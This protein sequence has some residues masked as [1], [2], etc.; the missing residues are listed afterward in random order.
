M[1]SLRTKTLI[2]LL[3]LLLLVG[4]VTFFA[5]TRLMDQSLDAYEKNLAEERL[6][7]VSQGLELSLTTFR[8]SATDYGQWDATLHFMQGKDPEY[9]SREYFRSNLNNLHIDYVLFLDQNGQQHA[10]VDGTVEEVT[11]GETTRSDLAPLLADFEYPATREK[12][13]DNQGFLLRLLGGQPY[14]LAFSAITA[15][16]PKPEDPKVGWLVMARR[17]DD[18]GMAELRK[19]T[20]TH[21]EIFPSAG[22]YLQGRDLL[23]FSLQDALGPTPIAVGLDRP[24]SLAAQRELSHKMLAYTLAFMAVLAGLLSI[25]IIERLILCR[26]GLFS[27]LALDD[28]KQAIDE[29]HTVTWPVKGEDELDNL[30]VSL[31]QLVSS[32]GEA[33]KRMRDDQGTLLEA[34]QQ[35]EY[36]NRMKDSFLATIS[37]ELRTP[38]NGIIGAEELLKASQPSPYQKEC[39]DTLGDASHLMLSMVERILLFSELQA[40][41][42]QAK[43]QKVALQEWAQLMQRFWST[44]F[45]HCPAKFSMQVEDTSTPWV[46]VDTVKV[47]QLVQELLR[48]AAKFTTKGEVS[49]QLRQ[50]TE[51]E[52]YW[53]VVDVRD[54]GIGIPED[55]LQKVMDAFR[56]SKD[57]YRR[58]YGGLGIGLAISRA[59]VQV[60]NAEWRIEST[61]NGTH[62][63]LR[64]PVEKAEAPEFTLEPEAPAPQLSNMPRQGPGRILLVEDNPVNQKIMKKILE[65]LGWPYQ[66]AENGL[67]AVEWAQKESFSMILMDCQMPVMDGLE[68]TKVIRHSAN[69]NQFTPIIAITANVS[70]LDRDNCMSVG[71]N[72]YLPKPVKPQQIHDTIHSW[73]A[74]GVDKA[75]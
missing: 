49:V 63:H 34:K 41:N 2:Y 4:V 32:L 27:R 13:V 12:L 18:K 20:G 44:I 25:I 66:T 6:A 42:A 11:R 72:A 71:M 21:I 7:R 68:A 28:Q 19:L 51:G 24:P 45:L 50:V 53:L 8:N 16:E 60:L 46:S 54:T 23:N 55:Q 47:D 39:L 58:N 3:S 59:I 43:P 40:G 14:A 75:G 1:K 31:N 9:L 56:P 67:E 52:R 22:N 57:R 61:D 38:M 33:Q 10:F 5:G 35:L 69:P 36:T 48:N 17:L 30:A 73:M 64:I 26:L 15:S 29:I 37:H 62:V 65:M 70:D 74:H